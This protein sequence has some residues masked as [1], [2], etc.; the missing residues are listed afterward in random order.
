MRL[1]N[2]TCAAPVAAA[3]LL[4]VAA[5]VGCAQRDDSDPVDGRSGLI[6]FTDHLTGCQYLSQPVLPG[7]VGADLVQRMRADGTQVCIRTDAAP[8][9]QLAVPMD[10]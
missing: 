6:V 10:Q 3:I 9:G 2:L 4:S 7:L 5:L 1:I 8:S